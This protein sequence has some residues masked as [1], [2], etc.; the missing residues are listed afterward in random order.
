[1]GTNTISWTST[2]TT[3]WDD[4]G[5]SDEQTAQY[6]IQWRDNDA[7]GNWADSATS[8]AGSVAIG[9]RTPPSA[10]TGLALTATAGS[11][12][13]G[14]EYVKIDWT[15]GV[16]D[17][18]GFQVFWNTTSSKP[19]APNTTTAANAVTYTTPDLTANTQYWVWVQAVDASGNTSSDVSGSITTLDRVAP[20]APIAPVWAEGAVGIA[21]TI[22]ANWTLGSDNV[23]VTNHYIEIRRDAAN[24][25]GTVVFTGATGSAA[26]GYAWGSAVNGVTYYFRAYTLDAAGNSSGYSG[27][28]AGIFIDLAPTAPTLLYVNSAKIGAQSASA[29]GTPATI[30]GDFITNDIS[31][32]ALSAVFNDTD[33]TDKGDKARVAIEK[34]NGGGWTNVTAGGF[35]DRRLPTM[36][37]GDRSIDIVVMGAEL[38]ELFQSMGSVPKYRAT[39]TFFDDYGSLGSASASIEFRFDQVGGGSGGITNVTITDGATE[40]TPGLDHSGGSTA[41]FFRLT[42]NNAATYKLVVKS[43]GAVTLTFW[44]WDASYSALTFTLSGLGVVTAGPTATG[45]TGNGWTQYQITTTT[46]PNADG[47]LLFAV[48][49]GGTAPYYFDDITGGQ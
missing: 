7:S 29:A 37:V 18:A 22:T 11:L 44:A 14:L 35:F 19:G 8:P 31:P 15:D 10:P 40:G 43:G 9:D 32:V 36:N 46:H 47:T 13:S 26:G 30:S 16:T 24:P 17:E 33:A 23:G 21:T 41:K 6:T 28:S 4:T 42:D 1:T 34:W 3:F 20:T 38:T 27:N 45:Q 48:Q 49:G 2:A 12:N 5:V 39:L 25:S